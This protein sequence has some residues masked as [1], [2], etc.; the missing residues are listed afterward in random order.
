M[1][2]SRV[3]LVRS[4]VL[5][6]AFAGSASVACKA[7]ENLQ[8]PAAP[9]Q[10][11]P[12]G[13]KPLTAQ[14]SAKITLTATV[15]TINHK[16]RE[17]TLVDPAGH[18]VTLVVSERVKRLDQVKVGDTLT[19][20]Y[21]VTIFGELR[22]PTA[23][24]KANPIMAV[25]AAA[26]APQNDAPGAGMAEA[27]KVV[28]TVKAVDLTNM[29]VTLQ[30]P[31]GDSTTIRA[32]RPEKVKQL[33]VGDTIVIT[34]AEALV[35]SLAKAESTSERP[36]T[37]EESAEVTLTATVKA[38][39]QETRQV[40][41]A[42]ASGREVS[43]VADKRIKRLGDVKVGD[44]VTAEYFVSLSAERRAPTAEEKANP[45]MAIEVAGKAPQAS[46]PGAGMAQAVKVVT[47]VKA[48][49]LPNMLV[50]FQGPMGD[51][52]TFHAK[53]AEKVKQ[54]KVGDTVIMT[55]A[56]ALAISLEHAVPK[57]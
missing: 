17:V 16:T 53:H 3:S 45:I 50:T 56:E 11:T 25:E 2:S 10:A 49:D 41:L 37:A 19:V 42:D 8:P 39:N 36:L 9:K 15:K 43:F 12:A 31:M 4:A 20:D 51:S 26:R 55:Y 29:L 13:A 38:I 6:A 33:K 44:T 54:L 5:V 28:T 18:E 27:V 22:P 35:V 34:Y 46:D 7:E 14:E 52:I 32:K 24:E 23:E 21:F 57:K 1:A 30:G 48:I 47:T 40:T